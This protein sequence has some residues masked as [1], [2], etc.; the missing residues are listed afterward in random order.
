MNH[1]LDAMTREQ[2]MAEVRK[3]RAGI[4]AHR[5]ASGHDLCWWHPHLWALLPEQA[6]G[7]PVVVPDWPQFMRG[8]VK[9]RASLD[10]Q[11]P[12]APRSQQEFGERQLP[13]P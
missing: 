13:A 9:Y 5:D 11:C 1:D 8:C 3:L 12:H 6:D 10:A 7:P 2:L 4:R